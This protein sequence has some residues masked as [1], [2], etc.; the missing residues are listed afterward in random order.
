MDWHPGIRLLVFDFPLR[1]GGPDAK[2]AFRHAVYGQDTNKSPKADVQRSVD[3]RR[4]REN[5]LSD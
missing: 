1:R 5:K 4:N 2:D 3:V